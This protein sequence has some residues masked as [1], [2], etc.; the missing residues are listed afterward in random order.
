MC[1]GGWIYADTNQALVELVECGS[2]LV[3]SAS[4]GPMGTAKHIIVVKA[5]SKVDLIGDQLHDAVWH[6]GLPCNRERVNFGGNVPNGH[7]RKQNRVCWRLSKE[8]PIWHSHLT[9]LNSH[10]RSYGHFK[11]WCFTRILDRKSDSGIFANNRFFGQFK[12]GDSKPSSLV[13]AG[14]LNVNVQCSHVLLR[15]GFYPFLSLSGGQFPSVLR[16]SGSMF[17]SN[18]SFSESALSRLSGSL[19][20]FGGYPSG[21]GLLASIVGIRNQDSESDN[22]Q[23]CLGVREKISKFLQETVSLIVGLL[24]LLAGWFFIRVEIGRHTGSWLGVGIGIAGICLL[25]FAQLVL[26]HLLDLVGW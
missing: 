3:P 12:I 7:S 15:A 10:S 11:G 22:L 19:G 5:Y 14:C 16:F 17:P 20:S 24:S 13:V 6:E 18:S 26:G 2:W 21:L 8:T 4:L 23:E 1:F 25:L 9:R